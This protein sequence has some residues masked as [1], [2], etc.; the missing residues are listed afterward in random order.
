MRQ[1]PIRQIG[2]LRFPRRFDHRFLQSQ[3]FLKLFGCRQQ[4]CPR[5]EEFQVRLLSCQ[6]RQNLPT[7]KQRARPAPH[8]AAAAP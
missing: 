7:V 1:Q 6:S 3:G 5:F 2:P 8:A 4:H